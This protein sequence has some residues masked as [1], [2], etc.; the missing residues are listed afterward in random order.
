[1]APDPSDKKQVLDFA[2]YFVSYGY[3]FHQKDMLQDRGRMD[4]YRDAIL[5]NPRSFKDKVV[6]DVGTGSGV[7]AIWAAKAGAKRVYA[8]EATSMA[9]Q[10]RRLVQQNGLSEVVTVLEGYMEQLELPEQVDIIVSE[11]MGYYLLRESMLDSVLFARQK[12]LKPDGAH[13][14]SHAQIYMAPLSTHILASRSTEYQEEV[15]QWRGFGEYM[16]ATNQIDISGLSAQYGREQ[17][18]YLMQTTQWSQVQDSEIIGGTF[19]VMEFAVESVELEQLQNVSS[20]FSCEIEQDAEL[21]GFGGWFDV[22]FNGSAALPTAHAVTLTTSPGAPTHWAQQVFLVSPAQPVKRGDV[23]E[24]RV[25]L[26]RQ[27]QNHRLLW[28][29]IRYTHTRAGVGPNGEALEVQPERTLN[30]RIE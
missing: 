25:S 9:Q 20:A 27:K 2:N 14:P 7:L 17:F 18:E 10:A 12:H 13:F 30:F 8:V 28:V 5:R 29:Q 26:R 16:R 22:Q 23:L 19:Q 3:L 6:L 1:M 15:A 24:G 4:A 21:S 11:W